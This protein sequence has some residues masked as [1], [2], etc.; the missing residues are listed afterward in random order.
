MPN[1]RGLNWRCPPPPLVRSF[2]PTRSFLCAYLQSCFTP[3]PSPSPRWLFFVGHQRL[4]LFQSRPPPP[5]PFLLGPDWA[6]TQVDGRFGCS[7]CSSSNHA[8]GAEHL[9]LSLCLFVC[10]SVHQPVFVHLLHTTYGIVA[11][12]LYCLSVC[13]CWD[14]IL[15]QNLRQPIRLHLTNQRNSCTL[16]WCYSNRWGLWITI[17]FF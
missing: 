7:S 6:S 1:S 8:S 4:L 9:H 15:M 16:H 10:L 11:D 5:T 13:E 14:N 3:Q 17:Q 2:T 12:K